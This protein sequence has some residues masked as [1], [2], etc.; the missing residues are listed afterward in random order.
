MQ[1]GTS[2]NWR[3]FDF[4]LLGAVAVLSIFGIAMIYSAIAE[5]PTLADHARRQMIFTVVGFVVIIM[6]ASIDYRLWAALSRPIY[7]GMFILLGV[8]SIVGAALFGSARW[9]DTGIILIQPSELAKIVMILVLADYFTQNQARIGQLQWVVRSFILTMGIVAW[10]LVQPNLSTSIVIIVIWFSLLWVSGLRLKHL[11]MFIAA[12]AV[13]P[14]ISFPFLVGYQQQRIVNF[15]FPDPSAPHGE[16]YNLQQAMI[17]I[18]SGGWFGK[19]YGLGSQVQLR[20]LKVRHSDF[21]FSAMA[22]EFGFIGTVLLMALIFFVVYRCIRAARLAKDT[23]GALIC[24]GVATL[25]AFQATV[26]IGVNLN[27]VP[28]TGLP[29]PFISYGGSSMLSLLLGIGLVESVILRH[30]SLEF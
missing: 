14:V 23:Y 30:K 13:T 2:T 19:G 8:L 22:E 11:L 25:L 20:F 12:G 21:I 27:L 24:Y 16:L 26:N 1:N 5:N 6:A 29:L 4:W 10:I 7:V 9:F 28:A 3:H 15:L 18:G 17:S